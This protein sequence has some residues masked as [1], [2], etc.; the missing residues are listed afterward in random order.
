MDRWINAQIDTIHKHAAIQIDNTDS[1]KQ[2][3]SYKDTQVKR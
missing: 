1:G 3:N 2:K